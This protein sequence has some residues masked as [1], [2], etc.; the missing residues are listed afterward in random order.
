MKEYGGNT[1]LIGEGQVKWDEILALCKAGG[2]K[3][4]IVE[5]EQY[6]GGTPLE[7][8][9]RSLENLKKMIRV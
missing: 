8:S 1:G 2:T 4:Y 6:G 9:R 3:W 5:Q 7:C